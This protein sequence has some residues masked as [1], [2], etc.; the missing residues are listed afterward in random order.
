[1]AADRAVPP[2]QVD[3]TRSWNWGIAILGHPR[4]ELPDVQTDGLI[5]IGEGVAVLNVR[6]ADDVELGVHPATATVHVR[7]AR[8]LRLDSRLLIGEFVVHDAGDGIVLED[9]DESL[10]IETPA[11]TIRV[12]VSAEEAEPSGLDEVWIDLIPLDE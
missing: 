5:S 9:A 11:S 1:M 4:A 8:E 12:I 2:S 3:L 6:H 7:S 10:L